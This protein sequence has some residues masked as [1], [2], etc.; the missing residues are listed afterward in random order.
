M[1]VERVSER[2]GLF[3]AFEGLHGCGKSTQIELL[4]EKL[5]KEGCEPVVTKEVSGTPLAD[6]IRELAFAPDGEALQDPITLTTLIAAS[7][8]TRVNKIIQPAL[9]QNKIVLADRYEGSMLVEQHYGQGVDE[10]Y[11][12]TLNDMV[13]RGIRPALTFVLDV[14]PVQAQRQ[15]TEREVEGKKP[16]F[17]DSQDMTYHQ[18]S[19]EAYLDLAEIEEGWLV[20]NAMRPRC[21]IADE[22]YS[23]V[24]PYLAGVDSHA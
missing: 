10:S 15:R 2:Q 20:I 24:Q 3:L 9:E 7:R 1:G 18:R 14:D 13:T 19:R 6:S 23:Y 12:R 4:R 17:W 8:S 16:S 21:D 5:I 11:V 22:I